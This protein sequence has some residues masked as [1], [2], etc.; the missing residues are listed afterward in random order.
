MDSFAIIEYLDVVEDLGARLGA[1]V[2][3]AA[4]YQIQFEGTPEIQVAQSDGGF[5]A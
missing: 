3:I 1:G 5:F 2:K 4:V